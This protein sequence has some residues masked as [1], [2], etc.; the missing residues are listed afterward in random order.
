MGV[1]GLI[2]LLL[3]LPGPYEIMQD[4]LM[5]SPYFPERSVFSCFFS[6]PLLQK[7]LLDAPVAGAAPLATSVFGRSHFIGKSLLHASALLPTSSKSRCLE[8]NTDPAQEF[9][10]SNFIFS[11]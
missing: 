8:G 10:L 4:V 6:L 3:E 7:R 5:N 1:A 9:I 11:S 2:W